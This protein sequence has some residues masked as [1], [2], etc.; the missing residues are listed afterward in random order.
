MPLGLVDGS[1]KNDQITGSSY[2]APFKNDAGTF[3]Y[4]PWRGRLNNNFYWLTA[5]S[6]PWIQVDFRSKVIMTGIKVQG[7]PF[8]RERWVTSLQIETGDS[9]EGLAYIK[10]G[11]RPKVRK[12]HKL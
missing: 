5:T 10:D 9:V 8:E 12:G 7:S 1:I 3:Y 6:N 11:L 4:E 2:A